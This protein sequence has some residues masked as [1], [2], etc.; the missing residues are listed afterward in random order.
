MSPARIGLIQFAGS[1]GFAKSLLSERVVFVECQKH[2]TT[3]I[4]F[5]LDTQKSPINTQEPSVHAK[6][7]YIHAKESCVCASRPGIGVCKTPETPRHLYHS[8]FRHAQKPH[9]SAK[10]SD[11]YTKEPWVHAKESYV[12]TKE[13]CVR[14]SQSKWYS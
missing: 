10:E 2:R 3:C 4:I 7:S 9:A 12:Y 13:P 14:Y 8:P 5:H 1:D 6:E 11:V